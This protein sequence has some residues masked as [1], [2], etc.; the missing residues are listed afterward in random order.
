MVK[1]AW[2]IGRKDIFAALLLLLGAACGL[3]EPKADPDEHQ[4]RAQA[5]VDE[6]QGG[7]TK[8]KLSIGDDCGK[9]GHNGCASGVC[10]HARP[11]PTLGWVCSK[12]CISSTD[13][14]TGWSCRGVGQAE[15]KEFC[16]PASTTPDAGLAPKAVVRGS[17]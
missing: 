14:L 6:V 11:E 15:R 1:H 16:V 7:N 3:N 5:R 13:C 9:T 8:K 2:D 12:Q 10:L 17:P 4:F